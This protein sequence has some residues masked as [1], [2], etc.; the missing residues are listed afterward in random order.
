[1][2]DEA[3][4]WLPHQMQE[5]MGAVSGYISKPNSQPQ[6]VFCSTPNRPGDLMHQLMLDESEQ[7]HRLRFD[8]KFGLEGEYPIFSQQQ[9]NE[10][11]NSREFPREMMLQFIGTVGD[12]FSSQSIELCQKHE[13]N[14]DLWRQMR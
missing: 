11:I 14:P 10:A 13:Y 9:I 1:M 6:I 12:V 2:V 5:V 8:Y 3:S 4:F 7:Y